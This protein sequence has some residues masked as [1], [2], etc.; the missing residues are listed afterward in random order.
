M[1][2]RSRSVRVAVACLL[3][4]VLVGVAVAP[5]LSARVTGEEY[6]LAVAPVDPVDPFRGAYVTLSYPDLTQARGDGSSL[7]GIVFV[8]LEPVA[9]S[10]LWRGR[11]AQSQRPARGPYLRCNADSWRLR[12]GIESLFASQDTASRLERELLDGAVATIRVDRRGNAAVLGVQ[13]DR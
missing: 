13:P 2:W 6:R 10:D 7:S 11:P 4:L 3:Q 5:S 12:C 1:S 9:G 8:P